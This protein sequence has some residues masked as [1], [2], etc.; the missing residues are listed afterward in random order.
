MNRP[1]S[2]QI[3]SPL[4]FILWKPSRGKVTGRLNSLSVENVCTLLFR[5]KFKDAKDV[6]AFQSYFENIEKF[7]VFQNNLNH[8][9]CLKQSHGQPIRIDYGVQWLWDGTQL[10]QGSIN[11]G[12]TCYGP[13]N[14]SV[15]VLAFVFVCVFVFVLDLSDEIQSNQ[16]SIND[17]ITC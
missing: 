15:F 5:W 16:R 12:I 2:T 13:S 10:N 11:D 1:W 14:I 4:S 8:Y 7:K 6:H 3:S 9:E 17:G